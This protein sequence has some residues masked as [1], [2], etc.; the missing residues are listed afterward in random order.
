MYTFVI[1]SSK[2]K[3]TTGSLTHTHTHATAT[4][5]NKKQLGTSHRLLMV[6]SLVQTLLTCAKFQLLQVIKRDNFA[7]W[8]WGCLQALIQTRHVSSSALVWQMAQNGRLH[9]TG[10]P[11]IRAA[12]CLTG[13]SNAF[14]A[15]FTSIWQSFPWF[16]CTPNKS[17]PTLRYT[18]R[19]LPSASPPYFRRS[20]IV[21]YVMS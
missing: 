2:Q 18:C 5:I 9:K 16:H 11:T 20:S 6:I 8:L 12:Q 10:E 21:H 3:H 13:I 14:S 7:D 17:V 19:H 1:P 15:S 4:D